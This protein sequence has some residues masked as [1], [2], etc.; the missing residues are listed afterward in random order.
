MKSIVLTTAVLTLLGCSQPS[1]AYT[2]EQ[3]AIAI[4]HAEGGSIAQYPFGIRS[5]PCVTYANCKS[6]CKTTI[7]NNRRRFARIRNTGSQSYFD[8]LAGRY[9][10]CEG[11]ISQTERAVNG[12]WKINVKYFLKKLFN[13]DIN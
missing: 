6:I 13:E 12:N 1:F 11:R 9:C 10:P 2:D 5:V 4:Y 3:L 8:Y 7:R